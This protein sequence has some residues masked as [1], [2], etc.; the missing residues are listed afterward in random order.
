MDDD[1]KKRANEKAQA[2]IDIIDAILES[3][4]E[5]IKTLKEKR[6]KRLKKNGKT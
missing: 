6:D 4:K 5:E 1:M 2:L 3:A